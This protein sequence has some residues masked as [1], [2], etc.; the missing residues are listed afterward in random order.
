MTSDAQGKF[1]P[2]RPA[3]MAVVTCMDPR[4]RISDVLG[5][6]AAHSFILRNGGGRVT[7]DVL[8]SLVL[9]TRLLKVT[10]VAVIHHTDCRLQDFTNEQLMLKTGID[11]D[12]MPFSNPVLSVLE[13]VERLQDSDLLSDQTHVWG[14]LYTVADHALSVVVDIPVAGRRARALL[15]PDAD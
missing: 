10:E 9:C 15:R 11:I 1:M 12:F 6:R 13:D 14:G 7:D 8:R 5:E 3:R 2:I 4:V